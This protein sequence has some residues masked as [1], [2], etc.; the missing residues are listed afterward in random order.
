MNRAGAI[1]GAKYDDEQGG[2][3]FPSSATL[4][5]ISFAVGETRYKV[6]RAVLNLIRRAGHSR[7]WGAAR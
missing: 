1:D 6:R 3:K 2:Y 5:D 4:P 7:T